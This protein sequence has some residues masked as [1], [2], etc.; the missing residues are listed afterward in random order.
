VLVVVPATTPY[1][2]AASKVETGGTPVTV[3]FGPVA[4]GIITNPRLAADQGLPSAHVLYVDPVGPAATNETITTVKIQPGASFMI[5]VGQTTNVSV[6]A[7]NSGH[8]FSAVIFQPKTPF[9]PTPQTGTFP[10]LAPTTMTEVIPSY[11][12]RQY[13]D[14]DA[15]QAFVQAFNSLTQS[16]VDWFVDTPLPV[17]TDDTIAGALLDWVA[18]GLYGMARPALSS[19]LFLSKGPLNTYEFNSWPLNKFLLEGP[20]NIT[21]TT[22]D[23][24]R[25]ILT[26]NFYKGDG[27]EFSIRWLKRRIL[28]FLI[29]VNGSAPN[30]D[31]T[32]SISITVGSG[33]VT[34][35]LSTGGLVLAGGAQ[36]NQIGFNG[37]ASPPVPLNSVRTKVVAGTSPLPL[38]PVLQEAVTLGVLILPFQY[39]FIVTL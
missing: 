36:F 30:V 3:A 19:G 28:R 17:Y 39:T 8:K 10:P 4:G 5:P 24:F 7:R 32:S 20:S 26:W 2:A 6:N 14:D 35:R 16:Y 38:A 27:N 12:Y 9:P 1:A 22:D 25:R 29:G 37:P 34:I 13:A 11:L 33:I 31:D 23:V 18:E 15:L 21:L